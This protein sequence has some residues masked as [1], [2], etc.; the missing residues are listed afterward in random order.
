MNIINQKSLMLIMLLLYYT[1]AKPLTFDFT[2]NRADV[3]KK[4]FEQFISVGN[5]SDIN[6]FLH[7]SL[8][9]FNVSLL[10]TDILRDKIR[11]YC[12]SIKS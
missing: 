7:R 6:I 11:T 10:Y 4:K 8:E 9:Y 2:C 12:Y 5:T 3:E 1:N